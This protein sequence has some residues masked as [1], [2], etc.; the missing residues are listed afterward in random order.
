MAG[1][2]KADVGK[3]ES[4]AEKSVRL[5]QQRVG[6]ALKYLNLVGNL[7]GTGYEFTPAQKDK[8]LTA[9]DEAVVRVKERF[10]GKS[11]A[12]TGFQL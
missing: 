7:A 6:M 10:G 12:A 8:M 11:Q 5:A 9:L 1:R 3:E 4:K 2:K